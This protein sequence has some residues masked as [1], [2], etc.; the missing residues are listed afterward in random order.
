MFTVK[1][2][3]SI[4]DN[5][6]RK[7]KIS[8][9]HLANIKTFFTKSTHAYSSNANTYPQTY[10]LTHLQPWVREKM[11]MN[12]WVREYFFDFNS[13][14][15]IKMVVVFSFFKCKNTHKHTFTMNILYKSLKH[16]HFTHF[17]TTMVV[18]IAFTFGMLCNCI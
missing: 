16:F 5:G 10:W 15:S 2:M 18:G 1:I 3:C 12:N 13:R 6:C 17:S 9:K 8:Y 7:T 14:F 4:R 11:L